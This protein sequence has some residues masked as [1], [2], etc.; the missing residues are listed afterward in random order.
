VDLALRLARHATGRRDLVCFAGAYH[1]WTTGTDET[2]KAPPWVHPVDPPQLDPQRSL[3]QLRTAVER[4]PPAALLCEPLL[5]NWGGV[6]LPDGWLA[7]AYEIVRAAGGMCIADEVQVGYGRPGSHFW[8]FEQQAVVPDLVTLAKPAGNGHPVGA[9][10]ATR[11]VADGFDAHEDLFS[12]PGGSPVSCAVGLAVLDA[13]ERE[14]LQDNARLV[15]EHLTER[16]GPLAGEFE[17]VAAL[18][19]IGLNRG[20]ELIRPDGSP[21]GAEAFALCERLLELGV[22]VQP[23]APGMN[24][25]KLK[26]PLCITR[27]DV[28]LLAAALRR[29]L[30]DGW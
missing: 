6:L 9:V 5:G 7:A 19:G 30:A 26:P 20:L 17:I 4:H 27:A 12:S 2:V 29:A 14:G 11:A 18:H 3:E 15:G 21:A 16:L 22:I 23:T 24:V 13:L 28:D 1:G 25:L 8:G 10:I